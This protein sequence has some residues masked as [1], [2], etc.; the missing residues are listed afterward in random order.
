ME[1]K[2]R[3]EIGVAQWIKGMVRFKKLKIE[4]KL[5]GSVPKL[6]ELLVDPRG[7]MIIMTLVPY[8]VILSIDLGI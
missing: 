1:E 4:K 7:I 5:K 2:E 6:F 8:H 3:Q